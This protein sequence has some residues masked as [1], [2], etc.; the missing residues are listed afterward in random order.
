MTKIKSII[1]EDEKRGMEK[2]VTMLNDYCPNIE[3]VEKCFNGKTAIQ[4]IDK[5]RPQLVFLD[6]DLGGIQGFDVLSSVSHITFET[7]ITT[8]DSTHGIKAVKAGALDYLVK[9]FGLEELQS[10]VKKAWTKIQPNTIKEIT[11]IALPDTHGA[12]IIPVDDI[13]YCTSDNNCSYVHFS[14][15]NKS[16]Y[17]VKTLGKIMEKL[18]AE[19]FCRVSRSNIIHLDQVA[20]YSRIDG[21]SITLLD[22]TILY[23]RPGKFRDEFLEKLRNL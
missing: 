19:K 20:S 9:P 16:L 17:V 5:L 14:N 1:V 11:K 21:G 3:I 6:L 10:A 2:I 12:N 7:I 8:G 4:A 23:L 22:G 15:G 13:M 18:P